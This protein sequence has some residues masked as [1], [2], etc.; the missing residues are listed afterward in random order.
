MDACVLLDISDNE[1]TASMVQCE[2]SQEYQ[3]FLP[4]VNEQQYL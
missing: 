3:Q 1:F 4:P 2:T